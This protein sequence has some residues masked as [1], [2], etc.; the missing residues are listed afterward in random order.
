MSIEQIGILSQLFIPG[1][2]LANEIAKALGV[3]KSAYS[4]KGDR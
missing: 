2:M 1:P 3:H 4:P